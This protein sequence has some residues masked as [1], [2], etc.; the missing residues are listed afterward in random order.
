[1]IHAFRLLAGTFAIA[2]SVFVAEASGATSGQY[3]AKAFEKLG[4]SA[5]LKPKTRLVAASTTQGPWL[6][7]RWPMARRN[8]VY[9]RLPS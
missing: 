6:D 4:I 1:M 5:E 2:T 3:M 8:S 7:K 9:S